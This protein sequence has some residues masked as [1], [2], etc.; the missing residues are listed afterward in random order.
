MFGL[1]YVKW[2]GFIPKQP[3]QSHPQLVHLGVLVH[4][5]PGLGILQLANSFA[6]PR[7]MGIDRLA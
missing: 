3:K 1:F 5:G 6:S 2:F 7:L 4:S